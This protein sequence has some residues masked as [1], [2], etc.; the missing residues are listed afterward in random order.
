MNLTKEKV[1]QFLQARKKA[2]TTIATGVMLCILSPM[3]LLVLLSLSKSDL[4]TLPS[5]AASAIGIIILLVI[6][7][8]SVALFVSA[9][10]KLNSF[11]KL[12]YDNF[13]LSTELINK[14]QKAKDQYTKTYATMTISAIVIFILS[15]IP[16][17]SGAFF[18][19]VADFENI[20][21]SLIAITLIP[22]SIGVFLLVKCNTIMNSYNV[23]LQTDDYTVKNKLGRK[24][25]EKYAALYWMIASLLYLSYSFITNDWA[26]SWIIW[27]ISGI[28]YVII[29]KIFALS[30][31]DLPSKE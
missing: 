8:I 5:N 11:E 25:M 31:K 27:P 26:H 16:V 20:M 24:K 2:A 10:F 15:A 7:A 23:L 18:E 6:I 22:I 19:D 14:V 3:S 30:Y 1:D 17:I 28:L 29:E 13:N 21:I 9:G 4:I 12:E